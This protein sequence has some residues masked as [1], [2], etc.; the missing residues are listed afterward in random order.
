MSDSSPSRGFE[1]L[2]S[3]AGVK[4]PSSG[5]GLLPGF[6]PSSSSPGGLPPSKR[7]AREYPQTG[8]P[9]LPSFAEDY[10]PKAKYPTPMP[11]SETHILSS[12]PPAG[13][14]RRPQLTRTVSTLSHREPLSA[15]P[16]AQLDISGEPMLFGRSGKSAHFQ[17]HS[18]S[19]NISRVHLRAAYVPADPPNSA[20]VEILCMGWN[21]LKVHCQGKHWKL[22]KEDS[23]TSES[24]GTDIMVDVA[25]TRVVVQWPHSQCKATTPDHSDDEGAGE[26]SPSRRA[27]RTLHNRAPFSEASARPRSPDSP[28]Q[29]IQECTPAPSDPPPIEIYEDHDSEEDA[30]IGSRADLTANDAVAQAS[31][32]TQDFSDGD[33]E[34]DPTVHSFGPMGANL[35]PQMASFSATSPDVSRRALEPLDSHSTSPARKRKREDVDAED[36][37]PARVL[38][39]SSHPIINHV[40]NQLAYNRLNQLPLSMIMNSLPSDLKD[41][42][43]GKLDFDELRR[44]I[45]AAACIGEVRRVG[46]DAS[47]AALESE[48]YYIPDEDF[49]DNRKEAVTSQ[50]RK[51]G[52][53]ACRKQHKVRCHGGLIRTRC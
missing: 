44:L 37:K 38:D 52:L 42:N 27:A 9:L 18:V 23:F 8:K 28:V 53:R 4:R 48:Y 6:D 29:P 43:G 35:L 11:T 12:S 39:V 22:Q 2:P 34:N 5:S 26:E 49:D 25:D 51:P 3:L 47:G 13:L 10:V 19:K 41:K 20:R 33:E 16:T 32:L 1:G 40:I 36:S 15:V 7:V 21:G 24:F 30:K 46:K 14:T 17:L 31:F 45:G 50:L